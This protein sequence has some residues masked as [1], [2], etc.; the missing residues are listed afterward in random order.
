MLA[1]PLG[2]IMNP[3]AISPGGILDKNEKVVKVSAKE[4]NEKS[5]AGALFIYS[6][7]SIGLESRYRT[8]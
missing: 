7:L 1:G 2:A 3:Q 5:P 6:S 4:I 8:S